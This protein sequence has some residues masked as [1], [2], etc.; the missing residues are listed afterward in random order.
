[1][2]R[3]RITGSFRFS[4][5]VEEASDWLG[6][7]RDL[8]FDAVAGIVGFCPEPDWQRTD[9]F[10]VEADFR[11][12]LA[13]L[14]TL[15]DTDEQ[16]AAIFRDFTA[17]SAAPADGGLLFW[18]WGPEHVADAVEHFHMEALSRSERGALP[19]LQG[20]SDEQLRVVAATG[21]R[22]VWRE[23]VLRWK[24]QIATLAG[25]EALPLPVLY[26]LLQA[27]LAA[28]PDDAAGAA[29][30][31]AEAA[32]SLTS[33]AMALAGPLDAPDA[34]AAGPLIEALLCHPGAAE[35]RAD[36]SAAA[37]QAVATAGVLALA[38][39]VLQCT[40]PGVPEIADSRGLGAR[41]KVEER[42]R[43]LAGVGASVGEHPVADSRTR[44]FLLR[45]LLALRAR[46]P[47]LFEASHYRAQKARG[48]LSSEVTVFTRESAGA[49]LLVAVP[50]TIPANGEWSDTALEI[51]GILRL[52]WRNVFT[53][54]VS[55]GPYITL[56]DAFAH[57][58]V[59][60]F[61]AEDEAPST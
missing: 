26:R 39:L 29:P 48:R 32:A 4:S 47:E 44:L 33:E 10:A 6:Y 50:R 52:H 2:N 53:G 16:A 61:V 17:Q 7:L 23:N 18:P 27:M 11:R 57:L 1:M 60:V 19:L 20:L 5:L 15:A 56:R 14:F 42:V 37:A 38:A 41:L 40:A 34:E 22:A 9:D 59:A 12:D 55:T 28:W 35:F 8:G 36:F 45:T 49:A 30:F 13:R 43:L 58:P 51:C 24:S 25:A 46:R 54:S 21:N 3:R 31:T